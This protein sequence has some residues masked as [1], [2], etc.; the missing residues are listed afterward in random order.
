M[1]WD[2]R[3]SRLTFG[4]H[5]T[6]PVG[7]PDG[8]ALTYL[9][10]ARQTVETR[11]A[12]GTGAARPVMPRSPEPSIPVAWTSDGRTLAYARLG[13]S[14]DLYLVSEGEPGRLFQKAASRPAFSPDGRFV[15][16]CSPASGR[17]SVF[18]RPLTGEGTWQICSPLSSS[19]SRTPRGRASTSPS[20]GPGT[21]TAPDPRVPPD[22]IRSRRRF[23]CLFFLTGFGRS[24]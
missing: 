15:A 16:Y 20:T 13:P 19:I 6:Y 8:R 2:P 4:S 22:V 24:G 5:S 1:P 3:A 23:P 21:S 17:S 10:L 9:D 11:P 12:D 18:V 7:R 14:T